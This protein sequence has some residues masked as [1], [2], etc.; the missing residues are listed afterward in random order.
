[1]HNAHSYERLDIYECVCGGIRPY[2]QYF[3]NNQGVKTALHFPKIRPDMTPPTGTR[4]AC[5]DVIMKKSYK[6]LRRTSSVAI[7]SV[8]LA[9][10]DQEKIL[11]FRKTHVV[12]V[13]K[14]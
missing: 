1:M 7:F 14:V 12:Y 13:K 5:C 6:I 11:N 10:S 9:L 2:T 8:L 4:S 3:G